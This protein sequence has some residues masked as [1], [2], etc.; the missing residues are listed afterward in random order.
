M[1]HRLQAG[2][3]LQLDKQAQQEHDSSLSGVLGQYF[4]QA[5]ETPAIGKPEGLKATLKKLLA[6]DDWP[7]LPAVR[8][9]AQGRENVIYMPDG[10]TEWEGDSLEETPYATADSLY[11]DE[12]GLSSHGLPEG[13]E[14]LATDGYGDPLLR[15]P[16][17]NLVTMFHETGDLRKVK[18]QLKIGPQK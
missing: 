3:E 12:T 4:K 18:T 16:E 13:Y 8:P 14:Y 5:E 11:N 1:D 15:D 10:R 6:P 7:L 2:L 17:G 9:I